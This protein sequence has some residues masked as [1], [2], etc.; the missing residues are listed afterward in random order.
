MR[1]KSYHLILIINDR[2]ILLRNLWRCDTLFHSKHLHTFYFN[3]TWLVKHLPGTYWI[4]L[5]QDKGK[6]RACLPNNIPAQV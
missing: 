5:C 2:V 4:S 6:K 1:Y 3:L